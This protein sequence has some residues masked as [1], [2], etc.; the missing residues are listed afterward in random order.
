MNEAMF[1]IK[2][3]CLSML[4]SLLL[5]RVTIP[6]HRD[7]SEKQNALDSF[8]KANGSPNPVL[9]FSRQYKVGSRQT[10]LAESNYLINLKSVY[11]D[12]SLRIIFGT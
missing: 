1:L 4:F 7:Q 2:Y 5:A 9:L 12:T 11:I 3:P 6:L 8:H 10:E